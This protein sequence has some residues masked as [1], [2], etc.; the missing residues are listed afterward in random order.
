VELY[1]A[2]FPL[3][4]VLVPIIAAYFF[5][6][7]AVDTFKKT[8]ALPTS[9]LYYLLVFIAVFTFGS[10]LIRITD[11]GQQERVVQSFDTSTSHEELNIELQ[12]DKRYRPGDL[13][14][15]QNQ[16]EME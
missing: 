16:T 10:G 14:K 8:K 13:S 9:P 7:H 2:W 11:P 5:V 1:F 4:A 15:N 6:K 12:A 3:V